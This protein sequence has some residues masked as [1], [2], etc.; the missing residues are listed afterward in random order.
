ME[1]A[2]LYTFSTIPQTLAAALGVLAA[3]VL[4]RL[5]SDSGT[6]WDDARE[7]IGH[8][9]NQLPPMIEG[10]PSLNDLLRSQRYEDFLAEVDWRTK[11]TNAP[12]QPGSVA[13]LAYGRLQTNVAARQKILASLKVAFWVTAI[14]IL[15][16]V[17]VLC[18]AHEFAERSCVAIPTL[19]LGV[20][21]LLIC[22]GLYWRLVKAALWN[23]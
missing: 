19:F 18:V 8:V 12:P 7:L 4:Y 5:Q 20:L 2:L 3:F 1:Y 6:R 23:A 11:A 9:G 13:Y 14:V 16:S 22:L 21:G 10:R 15:L 17:V